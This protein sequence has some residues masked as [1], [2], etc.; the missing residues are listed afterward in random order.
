MVKLSAGFKRFV[1]DGAVVINAVAPQTTAPASIEAIVDPF[2]K[3]LLSSKFIKMQELSRREGYCVGPTLSPTLE[4]QPFA[5]DTEIINQVPCLVA[6]LNTSASQAEFWIRPGSHTEY[7]RLATEY[8]T[9]LDPKQ[10]KIK[11]AAKHDWARSLCPIKLR[12]GNLVL[13]DSRCVVQLP[14]CS[15]VCARFSPWDTELRS[16]GSGR[17][18]SWQL[19]PPITPSNPDPCAFTADAGASTSPVQISG[20][21]EESAPS[22][23]ILTGPWH[24]ATSRMERVLAG[25][26]S[27]IVPFFK[28]G[29]I[30]QMTSNTNMPAT[31]TLPAH[32]LYNK[33]QNLLNNEMQ[34]IDEC[35]QIPEDLGGREAWEERTAQGIRNKYEAELQQLLQHKPTTPATPPLT[36]PISLSKPTA[37]PTSSSSPMRSSVVSRPNASKPRNHKVLLVAHLCVL[38]RV[39]L[40]F[41]PCCVSNSERFC[42]TILLMAE[43]FR[44][45]LV[46]TAPPKTQTLRVWTNIYAASHWKAFQAGTWVRVWRGQGHQFTIGWAK[47]TAM[48]KVRLGNLD[49]NGCCREGRP[50]MTP[51]AFL[52]MFLLRGAIPAKPARFSDSGRYYKATPFRPAITCNTEAWE[53]RFV[54]RP[55]K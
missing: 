52:K 44:D 48:R 9:C 54:F 31:Q 34:T 27:Y 37:S 40:H 18:V 17:L 3:L 30:V 6:L 19:P 51:S 14:N 4:H 41:K 26:L 32:E 12:P 8:R 7:A 46:G 29:K 21:F 39:P 20:L 53:V 45:N 33:Y 55:C 47:Y 11:L 36:K 23:Q 35:K 49:Q 25:G 38:S 50:L 15:Y 2:A 16:H 24:R 1:E 10:R 28:Q 43:S 5:G 13:W 22:V 42:A